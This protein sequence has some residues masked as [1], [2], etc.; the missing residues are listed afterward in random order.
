VSRAGLAAE[1]LPVKC[2]PK[3][4]DAR[5]GYKYQQWER[6]ERIGDWNGLDEQ[7]SNPISYRP[8]KLSKTVICCA[9]GKR[10]PRPLSG[11]AG[12]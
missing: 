11:K 3:C 8:E 12:S 5:Q 4:G 7:A 10:V 2:C 9:C 1:A 6:W